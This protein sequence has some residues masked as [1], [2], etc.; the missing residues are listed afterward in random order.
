[1]DA[2]EQAGGDGASSLIKLSDHDVVNITM[3]VLL[4]GYD[5]TSNTLSFASH[6]LA[7]HPDIQRKLQDEI[8]SY[9]KENPVRLLSC[10]VEV[11]FNGYSTVRLNLLV[12]N[13][14]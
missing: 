13:G 3:D 6:L 11:V 7:L 5:T 2:T 1:M 10:H 4:G 14:L 8:T 9:Y 12:I